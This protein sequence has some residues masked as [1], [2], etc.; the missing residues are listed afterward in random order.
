MFFLFGNTYT[1]NFVK[2]MCYIIKSM[3]FSFKC[4]I[5]QIYRKK[6]GI[7]YKWFRKTW[8][9]F[10]MEWQYKEHIYN[11]KASY[12]F[13][14]NHIV[15]SFIRFPLKIFLMFSEFFFPLSELLLFEFRGIDFY[16]IFFSFMSTQMS[17]QKLCNCFHVWQ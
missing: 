6:D 10:S 4:K 12:K 9:L 11:T 16:F 1:I 8:L 7:L 14:D 15:K 17:W 3:T 2:H 5:I 13:I